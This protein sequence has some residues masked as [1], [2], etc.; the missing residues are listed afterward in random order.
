MGD[1]IRKHEG[2]DVEIEDVICLADTD[3]AILVEIDG[4]QTWIPQSQVSENSEVWKKGDSGILIITEW[5]AKQ[6]N[7]W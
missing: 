1:V 2:E 3:K 4:T 5:I 6:K 7:L